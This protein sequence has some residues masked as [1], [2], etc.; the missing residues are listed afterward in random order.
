MKKNALLHNAGWMLLGNVAS[1]GIQAICFVFTARLLGVVQYGMY[2]GATALVSIVSQYSA[3]GS[4]VL[5]LRYVSGDRNRFSAYWGNILL[6]ISFVGGG[7]VCATFLFGSRIAGKEAGALLIYV[8]LGDC[9]GTQLTLCC[10]QVFIAYEQM[11]IAAGLQ[12]FANLLRLGMLAGVY[13]MFHRITVK[14]WVVLQMALALVA[15]LIAAYIVFRQFGPPKWERGLFRAR[16]VEGLTFAFSGSTTSAYNDIDKTMLSH[17]GMNRANGTYSLAYRVI[18]LASLPVGSIHAAA[19]PRFCRI[20]AKGAGETMTYA[21]KILRRTV[22]L[23]IA[24]A[25]GLWFTAPL[26]PI[27]AGSGFSESVPAVRWLCLLPLFRA[28]HVCAGDAMVGA[29]FQR[30]RL[31]AQCLA[32][33]GNFVLNLWLIPHYGWLGAAWSSLATDGALGAMNWGML[34]IL[35]LKSGKRLQFSPRAS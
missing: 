21:V 9:I 32:A 6:S 2:A 25:A 29:G 14:Q 11:R 12:I 31:G 33:V 35:A 26:L 7:L 30:Y 27:L 13:V 34:S 24:S 4:G 20:G 16:A 3:F 23:G 1:Y 17:F 22:L 28:F 19:F 18:N 10:S 5:F 8:A 15:A